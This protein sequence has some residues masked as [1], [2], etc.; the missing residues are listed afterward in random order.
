MIKNFLL[1]LL[2]I[3][4]SQLKSQYVKVMTWNIRFDN[5]AD[6]LDQWDNRKEALAKIVKAEK[7]DFFGIQEGLHHQVEYLG[8][9]LTS[10]SWTG[11]GRDDGIKGGE[12]TALYYDKAKW[13]PL[14]TSQFWLSDTPQLVS[15]GWDAACHRI[16][17]YGM[18]TNNKGDTIIVYN[19]HFDH[20]GEIARK[21]SV[22]QVN[23]LLSESTYPKILMGDFN[24]NPSSGLYTS[25]TS[26]W[27]DSRIIAKKIEISPEGTFNGF[28]VN[29]IPKNRIDYIFLD[30]HWEVK[31]YISN[32]KLTKK[33]RH[34]SDHN[35]VIAELKLINRKKNE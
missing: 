9:A 26:K 21:N 4:T 23:S 10:Y 13:S 24:F 27:Y 3:S 32:T 12:Y 28:K 35:F 14:K 11:V 19:T 16:T 17:T 18:F 8:N 29:E 20:M 33:G 34:V 2:M 22:D 15:R 7:P 25:I 5:K 30:Q 31:K 6:S 1:I